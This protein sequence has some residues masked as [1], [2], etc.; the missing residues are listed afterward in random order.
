MKRLILF[1]SLSFC[2]ITARMMANDADYGRIAIFPIVPEYEDIPAGARSQLETKL[3]NIVS[4]YG[5]ESTG[6]TDRFV[7]TAKISVTEH[8]IIPSNPTRIQQKMDVTIQIG[9][10][11]DK[12]VFASNVV[13]VT[14]LGVTEEKSFISAFSRIQA[15]TPDMERMIDEAKQQII[16]YYT[17]KCPEICQQAR[18]LAAQQKF[19]QAMTLLAMIPNVCGDCYQQSRELAISIYETQIDNEGREIIQQA[20]S[21]WSVKQDYEHAD[22][23]LGLLAT[24]NPQAKCNDEAHAFVQEINNQLRTEEAR[25]EAEERARKKAEWEFKMRKYEDDL[26]DRRLKAER[27]HESSMALIN[28]VLGPLAG[29]RGP[30][31]TMKR[32]IF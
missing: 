7:I 5:M 16:A 24:I 27:N 26:A 6:G 10:V 20:R 22:K 12:K 31:V 13:N 32:S 29:H 23:A 30:F 25:L 8:N 3:G 1:L 21:A 9:D 18:M 11:V 4:A 17:D 2:M 19:T 15:K 14:G 28:N